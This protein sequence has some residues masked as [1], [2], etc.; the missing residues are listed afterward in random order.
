M[1]KQKVLIYNPTEGDGTVGDRIVEDNYN[2]K[3]NAQKFEDKISNI[4][5]LQKIQHFVRDF[6]ANV[7]ALVEKVKMK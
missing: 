2:P 6:K 7:K 5:S 1:L 3:V 4:A